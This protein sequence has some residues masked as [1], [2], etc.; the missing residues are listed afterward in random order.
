[1]KI[2]RFFYVLSPRGKVL[3]RLRG[4]RVEGNKTDC[5][6]RVHKGWPWVRPLRRRDKFNNI[7]KNCEKAA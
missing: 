2:V 4:A 3:H 1:M 7:C 6:I 5:G